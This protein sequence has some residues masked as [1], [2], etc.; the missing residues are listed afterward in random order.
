MAQ[1]VKDLGS[2]LRC[3]FDPRQERPCAVGAAKK[4]K[5]KQNSKMLPSPPIQGSMV[6]RLSHLVAFPV[7]RTPLFPSCCM[8][9]SSLTPQSPPKLDQGKKISL[10]LALDRGQSELPITRGIQAGAGQP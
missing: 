4:T 6:M 10:T 1:K 9:Q 7:L 5:Q 8:G 2:P 3:Q